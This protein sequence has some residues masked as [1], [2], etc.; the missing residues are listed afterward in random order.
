FEKGIITTEDTLGV[1]LT[2]GNKDALLPL[3]EQMAYRKG[4]GAVLA[5]G[6]RAAAGKLGRGTL[7][8]AIQAGG[9][10]LPMHDARCWP[11]FGY[12]YA[13]DPTP[14]I[15]CKGPVGFIEHGWTDRQLEETHGMRHLTD[16][17][18]SFEG[19]G[20]PLKLL[21]HWYHFFNGT[22]LCILGKYCYYRY[23]ALELLR[24]VTGWTD[25]DI[26]EALAVGERV[27]TLRQQFNINEGITH[28]DFR[29]PGRA[30]GDPPLPAGPT[31][32]VTVDL[33]KV[34]E[35]YYKEMDWDGRGRPSRRAVEK[36]GLGGLIKE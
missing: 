32:G 20:K 3:I 35:D 34:R 28:E 31:A 27:N 26:E 2:W 17:K 23:P 8:F 21:S 29:P 19:K 24:A 10:E 22:G 15:H 6:S 14:G 12:S 9:V 16:D 1:D 7:E 30:L 11:G 33:D 13:L 5:D 36:L 4:I 25:F 18:Y